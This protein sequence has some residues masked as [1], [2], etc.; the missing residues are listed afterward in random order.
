MKCFKLKKSFKRLWALLYIIDLTTEQVTASFLAH[1][2]L[3]CVTI[4]VKK[5][6]LKPI[7]SELYTS[8][9]LHTLC[10]VVLMIIQCVM[11]GFVCALEEV[12]GKLT[13]MPPSVM[14]HGPQGLSK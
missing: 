11:S 4:G 6:T 14:N 8:C 12:N 7:Y 5:G 1:K 3:C 13:Q 10:S 9:A 2:K